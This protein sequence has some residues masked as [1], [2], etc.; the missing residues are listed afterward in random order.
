MGVDAMLYAKK[1]NQYYDLDRDRNAKIA[2]WYSYE[3]EPKLSAKEIADID[4]LKNKLDYGKSF[5][6]EEMVFII[7]MNIK[8]AFEQIPDAEERDS[9]SQSVAIFHNSKMLV[10]VLTSPDDEEFYIITDMNDDFY[11]IQKQAKE[12]PVTKW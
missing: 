8:V 6:K 5:T 11:D 1:S 3:I 9:F 10:L 4:W 2:F 7:K 12:H